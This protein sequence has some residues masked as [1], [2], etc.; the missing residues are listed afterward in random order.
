MYILY[1]NRGRYKHINSHTYIL[2]LTHEESCFARD[3]LLA[4][5]TLAGH[6]THFLH[7][8]SDHTPG[9]TC[10]SCSTLAFKFLK[11]RLGFNSLLEITYDTLHAGQKVVQSREHGK[12]NAELGSRF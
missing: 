10:S 12:L 8:L 2:G 5:L 6:N 4:D 11:D 7:G 1:T 9:Y 3:L